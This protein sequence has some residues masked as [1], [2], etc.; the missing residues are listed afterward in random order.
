MGGTLKT[1]GGKVTMFGNAVQVPSQFH[2]LVSVNVNAHSNTTSSEWYAYTLPI[3][4]GCLTGNPCS[5]LGNAVVAGSYDKTWTAVAGPTTL[6]GQPSYTTFDSSVAQSLDDWDTCGQNTGI[7]GTPCATAPHKKVVLEF[8]NTL[9]QDPGTGNMNAGPPSWFSARIPLASLSSDSSGNITAVTTVNNQAHIFVGTVAGQQIQFLGNTPSTLNGVYTIT[10]A[11]DSGTCPSTC[12]TTIVASGGP[13]SA[14]ASVVGTEGNPFMDYDN[15]AIAGTSNDV[16]GDGG[17]PVWWSPNFENAWQAFLIH[18]FTTYGADSRV[19]LFRPGFGYGYENYPGTN[20]STTASHNCRA[21][22]QSFGYASGEP[23]SCGAGGGCAYWE[24][25]LNTQLT[26]AEANLLTLTTKPV[27]SSLSCTIQGPGQDKAAATTQAANAIAAGLTL[28]SNGLAGST[29]LGYVYPSTACD[30]NSCYNFDTYR[31]PRSF[32]WQAL[33]LSDPSNALVPGS[34]GCTSSN[35]KQSAN[36]GAWPP[37]INVVMP[38]GVQRVEVF[39]RDLECTETGFD[40]SNFGFSPPPI[41][42]YAACTAAGYLQAFLYF[43]NLF[44]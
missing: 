34:G 20:N 3:I 15:S 2:G 33:A 42:N 37:L 39:N 25:Y 29:D 18:E 6:G 9:Y 21:V 31:G 36:T 12:I 41:I 16:C 22:L 35:C 40:A 24:A 8:A 14:T 44:D 1:T 43:A 38:R 4:G 19:A 17:I 7:T 13:T 5:P 23:S 27:E 28:N 11:T 30:N 10:S 26:W 32:S